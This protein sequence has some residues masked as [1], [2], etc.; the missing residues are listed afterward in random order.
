MFKEFT[1]PILAVVENYN[2]SMAVLFCRSWLRQ[3][4][5]P[6]PKGLSVRI[7]E[8]L[9]SQEEVSQVKNRFLLARACT[10]FDLGNRDGKIQCLTAHSGRRKPAAL[11][12]IDDLQGSEKKVVWVELNLDRLR[13]NKFNDGDKLAVLMAFAKAS[14][15][16]I[17]S[18]WIASTMS[19]A[20]R[21]EMAAIKN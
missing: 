10:E 11:A 17:K 2:V 14:S 13:K 9:N 21:A 12:K 6:N 4:I 19:V 16:V 8:F 7:R 15:M 18:E 20:S 3:S 1:E 5:R